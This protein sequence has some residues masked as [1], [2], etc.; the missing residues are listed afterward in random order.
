MSEKG[1]DFQQYLTTIIRDQRIFIIILQQ[2]NL[3][4]HI[5]DFLVIKF[6][7]KVMNFGCFATLS[8]VWKVL[9]KLL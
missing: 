3:W 8:H 9:L 7:E 6:G 1:R 4:L 2:H 5:K